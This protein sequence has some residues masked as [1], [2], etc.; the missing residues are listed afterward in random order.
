MILCRWCGSELLARLVC[1]KDMPLTDDFVLDASGS[2]NEL[3]NDIEIFKCPDCGLIQNPK[4]FDYKDYYRDYN[5]TSG[6]SSFTKD[7]MDVF[8]ESI[9]GVFKQV[10]GRAPR[11]VLEVGSGDG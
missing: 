8:S 7:F 2:K 3:I 6:S 5:Y 10:A 9:I 4:D 1:L 11:S